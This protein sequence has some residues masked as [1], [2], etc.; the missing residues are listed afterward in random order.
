MGRLL[1]EL[2]HGAPR[3]IPGR[4][5]TAAKLKVASWRAATCGSNPDA[6]PLT[7]KTDLAIFVSFI[8]VIV[9]LQALYLSVR[10][11]AGLSPRGKVAASLQ[12]QIKA[13][14]T[15]TKS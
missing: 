13:T 9:V 8:L 12:D 5:R 10:E 15:P 2:R 6:P 7:D 14:I 1:V 4:A 11:V 3:T